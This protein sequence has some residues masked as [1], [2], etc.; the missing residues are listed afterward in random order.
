MYLPADTRVVRCVARM[1]AIFS[2]DTDGTIPLTQAD[3]AS[4]A[5]VTRSTANRVLKAAQAKGVLRAGRATLEVLDVGRLQHL[6]GL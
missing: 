6:A 4:M 3:I 2:V 5:G 1:Y